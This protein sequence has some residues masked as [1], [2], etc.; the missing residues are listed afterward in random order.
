M[1]VSVNRISSCQKRSLDDALGRLADKEVVVVTVMVDGYRALPASLTAIIRLANSAKVWRFR[2]CGRLYSYDTL[3]ERLA[4]PFEP[5]AAALRPFIPE[6]HTVV[7]QRPLA[8]SRHR[9][10]ADQPRSRENLVGGA[11]RARRH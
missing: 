5:V 7:G 8:R 6:E 11:T 4:Q 3:L 10:A 9:P 1:T 2:T